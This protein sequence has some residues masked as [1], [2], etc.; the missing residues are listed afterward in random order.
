LY[1]NGLD[2]SITGQ[3]SA[4]AGTVGEAVVKKL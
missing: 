3:N 1:H 4:S 2:Q